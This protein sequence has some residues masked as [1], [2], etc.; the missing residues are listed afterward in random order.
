M[1]VEMAVKMVAQNE[2]GT[3]FKFYPTNYNDLAVLLY[4]FL[5]LKTCSNNNLLLNQF[6]YFKNGC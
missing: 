3:Y 1:A 2:I 4:V 5:K 6:S